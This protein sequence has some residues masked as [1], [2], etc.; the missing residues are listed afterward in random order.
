MTAPQ[1]RAP[2][3]GATLY[4]TVMGVGMVVATV[5]LAA[6][7]VA[8]IAAGSA[9]GRQNGDLAEAAAR[10]GVEYALNWLNRTPDWRTRLDSGVD[11]GPWP[12]LSGSFT[13]R[14]TDA[15]GDLADDP[16]D[17]ATLRVR[18]TN[19]GAVAVYEVDVEPAGRGL[20]CLEAVVCSAGNVTIDSNARITGTGFVHAAGDVE[21]T[22]AQVD[23]DVE[24][25]GAVN[26]SAYAGEQLEAATVRETPGDHVFDWYVKVGTEIPY[27]SLAEFFGERRMD[28]ALLS[29]DLNT[30]GEANPRGVYWIDCGGQSPDLRYSRVLGTLVLLNAGPDTRIGDVLRMQSAPMNY[31]VLLVQGNLRIDL[32]GFLTGQQLPEA[33]IRNYN[34][35]GIPYEGVTDDDR[36]DTYPACLDGVVYVS[37]TATF[38][39]DAK[40][41]GVLVAGNVVFEDNETLEATHWPYAWNYPPPGFSAGQ[42]VRPLPGTMRRVGM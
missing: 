24:A 38:T 13:W 40:L 17:H 29:R 1:R 2:R 37:G 11:V 6:S 9:T 4:V 21:A 36:S 35:P 32:R 26:G 7:G 31:P 14:V 5:A 20:T 3:R 28:G 16:R 8:R 22:G 19:R 10:S 42:G 25:G 12:T 39:D 27:T 18:G 41:R 15:D 34:P 30:F 33:G 23:L